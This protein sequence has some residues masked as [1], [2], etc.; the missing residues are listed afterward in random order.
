MKSFGLRTNEKK[1]M[2]AYVQSGQYY[3]IPLM[4]MSRGSFLLTGVE[5][6]EPETFLVLSTHRYQLRTNFKALN[7]LYDEI[8]D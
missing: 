7:I 4:K 1:I 2:K 8:L 5:R 3:I 6:F